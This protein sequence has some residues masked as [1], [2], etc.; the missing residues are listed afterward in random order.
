ML[1]FFTAVLLWEPAVD[2]TPQ[3]HVESDR[4][5]M[6][7]GGPEVSLAG[8]LALQ[9]RLKQRRRW[10]CLLTLFIRCQESGSSRVPPV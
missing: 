1:A 3:V 2:G 9:V 4:R 5:P 6:G 10:V 8:R 7:N